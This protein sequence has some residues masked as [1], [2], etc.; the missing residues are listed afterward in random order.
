MLHATRKTLSTVKP[1]L[2][3]TWI[4]NT[5]TPDGPVFPSQQAA[6]EFLGVLDTGFLVAYAIVSITI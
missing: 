6:A 1:S 5:S 3:H 4:S 2:I